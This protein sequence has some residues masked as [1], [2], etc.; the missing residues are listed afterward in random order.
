MTENAKYQAQK[1]VDIVCESYQFTMEEVV[2]KSRVGKIP[3]AR[4]II[5]NLL[6]KYT[7]LSQWDVAHLLNY[8]DHSSVWRDQ[9]LIPDLIKFNKD[10]A[11]RVVPILEKAESISKGI[12][13]FKVS[14]DYEFFDFYSEAVFEQTAIGIPVYNSKLKLLCTTC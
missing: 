6:R 13:D 3:E 12:T 8:R 14:R 10:Y 1:Y 5:A 7:S 9:K 2:S 4:Q 11:E